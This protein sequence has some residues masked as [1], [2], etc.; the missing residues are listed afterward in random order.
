MVQNKSGR[1][2][3]VWWKC[4]APRRGYDSN[5]AF[6]FVYIYDGQASSPDGPRLMVF[7]HTEINDTTGGNSE[8]F[9]K[10]PQ[11]HDSAA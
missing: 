6:S 11:A 9:R 8:C 3:M 10:K 1:S 5:M 2:W 4:S 7:I